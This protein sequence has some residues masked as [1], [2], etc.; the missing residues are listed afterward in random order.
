MFSYNTID[1]TYAWENSTALNGLLKEELGFQGYEFVHLNII[2]TH[3]RCRYVMSNW[4]ATHSGL[5]VILAGLDM[6][7]SV[8]LTL[9][10]RFSDKMTDALADC[11][12]SVMDPE[13]H[14]AILAE[15]SP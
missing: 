10:K 7:T 11:P 4:R 15:T 9:D 8:S 13:I 3:I 12:S 1:Q 2:S 6:D 5:P 14:L